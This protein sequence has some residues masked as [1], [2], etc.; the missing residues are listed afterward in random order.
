[1][2]LKASWTFCLIIKL[3]NMLKFVSDGQ[4]AMCNQNTFLSEDQAKCQPLVDE[5]LHIKKSF[6]GFPSV[7]LFLLFIN[8]ASKAMTAL[9]RFTA[10]SLM[11][12]FFIPC[13]LLFVLSHHS[14]FS[15]SPVFPFPCNTPLLSPLFFCESILLKR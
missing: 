6:K 7:Q 4:P 11:F 10:I 15:R 2:V 12:L 14:D 8:F 13:C 3:S 5:G 9:C 1:M